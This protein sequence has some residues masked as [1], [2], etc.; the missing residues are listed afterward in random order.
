MIP[1]L[2]D[3]LPNANKFSSKSKAVI[4]SPKL[5]SIKYD[6]YI[7]IIEINKLIFLNKKI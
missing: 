2:P 7:F 4:G 6:S 5:V 1:K 3:M